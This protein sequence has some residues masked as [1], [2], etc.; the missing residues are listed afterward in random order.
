MDI[1]LTA[2]LQVPSHGGNDFVGPPSKQMAHEKPVV[3]ARLVHD[4][5]KRHLSYQE[6][7]KL[8]KL[9][10]RHRSKVRVEEKNNQSR[11]RVVGTSNSLVQ[12]EVL[13]SN[14]VEDITC[15]D[16]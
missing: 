6:L 3:Q 11:E 1:A 7:L 10:V 12:S 14:E 13:E 15:I 4:L 8:S 2:D 16:L 5:T 9:P